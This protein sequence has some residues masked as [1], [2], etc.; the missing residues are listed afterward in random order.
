MSKLQNYGVT[1]Y[2][3]KFAGAVSILSSGSLYATVHVTDAPSGV[4]GRPVIS[5]SPGSPPS[6]KLATA[7]Q[8]ATDTTG[9]GV[10]RPASSAILFAWLSAEA[11]PKAP[12][13]PCKA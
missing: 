3:V 1:P 4:I 7:V 12:A 2:P 13:T 11:A 5:I 8:L 10:V 6:S 9:V